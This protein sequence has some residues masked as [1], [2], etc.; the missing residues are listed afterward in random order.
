MDRSSFLKRTAVVV[1]GIRALDG[2]AVEE[3][4]TEL[5]TFD[6]PDIHIKLHS[7]LLSA[8]E[9]LRNY[10]LPVIRQHLN[11]HSLLLDGYRA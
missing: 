9:A 11:Q 7:T 4:F 6:D 1:M 8:D 3:A 10:Y 5:V 2:K